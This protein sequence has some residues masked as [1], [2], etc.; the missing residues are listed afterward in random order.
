MRAITIIAVTNEGAARSRSNKIDSNKIDSN[1]N[2]FFIGGSTSPGFYG[3][4]RTPHAADRGAAA[5]RRAAIVQ[6]R[7]RHWALSESGIASRRV[8]VVGS[9]F[10]VLV[11][12]TVL[13]TARTTVGPLLQSAAAARAAVQTGAIVYALPDGIYCRQVSFDNATAEIKESAMN[14]CGDKIER[15]RVQPRRSFAWG[16]H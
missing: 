10:L 7:Q 14:R 1:L 11:T 13:V 15:I 6:P 9:L 3:G 8:V 4:M 16:P 12:T 2:R 5:S